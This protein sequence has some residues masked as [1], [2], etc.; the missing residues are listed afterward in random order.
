[1]AQRVGVV[2]LA[3]REEEDLGIEPF[4]SQLELLLAPH[5]DDAVEPQLERFR[6]LA[7]EPVPVL[8]GGLDRDHPR[9]GAGQDSLGRRARGAP[10]NR[11]LGH[12]AQV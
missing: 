2:L 3:Q 8:A 9:V 5:L 10:E 1:M 7:G 4:E 11:Q 12:V 6:M